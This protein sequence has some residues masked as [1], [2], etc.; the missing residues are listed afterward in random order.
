[1]N[2]VNLDLE[3]SLAA[4]QAATG[5]KQVVEKLATDAAAV[6]AE[7]G[8]YAMFLYLWTRKPTEVQAV[9]KS[10]QREAVKLLRAH[11][12]LAPGGDPERDWKQ[13][14]SG[15]ADLSKDLGGLLLARK[16]MMQLLT[17]LRYEAKRLPER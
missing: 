3:C 14:M 12:G 16:L 5:T 2:W 11:A 15:V 6:L 8:L 7:N 10:V 13:V 1:M 4:N 9:A 17:Y